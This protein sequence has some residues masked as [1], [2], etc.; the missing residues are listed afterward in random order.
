MNWDKVLNNLI[1][2]FLCIY[3][4][5]F[6]F[7][8][9]RANDNYNISNERKN[10][11]VEILNNNSI[12]LEAKL[13]SNY[14]KQKIQLKAPNINKKQI[15]DNF[16]GKKE[17]QISVTNAYE[18]HYTNSQKIIFSKGD[19]KG[20]V[21]YYGTNDKYKVNG[22]T[23]QA[24]IDAGKKVA[25]DISSDAVRLKLTSVEKLNNGYKLEF[26]EQYRNELLFCNH[27]TVKLYDNG[28]I[29]AS[30]IRYEPIKYIQSKQQIYPVDMILY[31]FMINRNSV[32]NVTIKSIKLGYDLAI[33][34]TGEAI[35]YYRINLANGETYYI[36]GYTNLLVYR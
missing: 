18:K 21:I 11:L 9:F 12:E 7:N 22:S 32:E 10:Q 16:F 28:I 14:P 3:G 19:T 26:N 33:D 27:V 1:I 17:K 34:E 30:T 35:P 13:P 4:G 25:F 31:N 5:L 24:Y 23:R 8:S 36:N 29:D 2:I 6:L 15:L 20:E